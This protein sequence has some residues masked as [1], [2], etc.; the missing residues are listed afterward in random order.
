[1]PKKNEFDYY[2]QIL[3][4]KTLKSTHGL[5]N[6]LIV[7]YEK[8]RFNLYKV[9]NNQKKISVNKIIDVGI[10]FGVMYVVIRIKGYEN[11]K[12]APIFITEEAMNQI[13]RH[14]VK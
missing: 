12:G 2:Y 3:C 5:N 8:R 9:K 10:N 1:M 4:A 11:L 13:R 7:D 14:I 6:L